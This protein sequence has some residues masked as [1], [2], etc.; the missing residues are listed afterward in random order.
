MRFNPPPNWPAPPPGWHPPPGWNPDPAWGPAPQGWQ[1]WVEDRPYAAASHVPYVPY[2]PPPSG[3]GTAM[4]AVAAGTCGMAGFVPPLYAARQRRD[5][6]VYRRRMHRTAAVL[7]SLSGTVWILAFLGDKDREGVLTGLTGDLASAAFLVNL[8]ASVTV[9][10]MVR[11]PEEEP[12]P[13]GVAEGLARRRL[14]EQYREIATSDRALARTM[15]VGRPDLPRTLDDGGLLDLNTLPADQLG[16]FAGLSRD[17]TARVVDTRQ[18]LGRLSSLDELAVYAD[19]SPATVD[20]LR[21]QAV[22]L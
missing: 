12:L 11:N 10:I 4:V 13:P 22:F 5:D 17:E 14:R 18:R 6:P 15:L 16:R 2:V 21:E 3:N 1:L 9:A 8:I 20:A 19:L 7:L